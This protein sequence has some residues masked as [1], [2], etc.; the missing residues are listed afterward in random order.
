MLVIEDL[1]WADRST[2]QLLAFLVANLR[3]ER[4]LVVLTQRTDVAEDDAEARAVLAELGR[5]RTLDRIDLLPF[6]AEEV[7]TLVTALLGE[8]ADPTVAGRVLARSD[9]NAFLVG[10]CSPPTPAASTAPCRGA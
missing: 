2:L 4:L 9:G 3:T 10:S 8:G 1:H 7:A 5:Q 6:N